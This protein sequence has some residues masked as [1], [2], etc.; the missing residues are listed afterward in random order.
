MDE[1]SGLES[2]FGKRLR[3]LREERGHT[4]AQVVEWLVDHGVSYMNTSTLS[5]IELG[6][7]P[8]R[9]GE[10]TVFARYFDIPMAALVTTSDNYRAID[11]VSRR[12]NEARNRFVRFR[13]AVVDV[14]RHQQSL[15]KMLEVLD[16]VIESEPKGS[17]LLKPVK[18]LRRNVLDFVEIDL[19]EETRNL[20]AETEARFEQGEEST[21]GRFLNSR[22]TR[23]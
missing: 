3:E 23:G 11:L 20:V 8:V 4:Q 19:V 14:S 12:H 13:Q 17:E 10:A 1:E 5:R 22:D 9:L 15:P 18:W 2:L 16:E 6:T 21:A 7:R